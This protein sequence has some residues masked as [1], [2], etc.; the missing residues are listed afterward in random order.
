MLRFL[1][2]IH[3]RAGLAVSRIRELLHV[4]RFERSPFILE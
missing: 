4:L 2:L 3:L 1:A